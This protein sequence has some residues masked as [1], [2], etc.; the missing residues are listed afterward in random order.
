MPAIGNLLAL[1]ACHPKHTV[2]HSILYFFRFRLSF[3][4]SHHASP[5][6]SLSLPLCQANCISA[7]LIQKLLWL[8]RGMALRSGWMM[9]LGQTSSLPRHD[10]VTEFTQRMS[11]MLSLLPWHHD[12]IGMHKDNDLGEKSFPHILRNKE[13]GSYIIVEA[14]E[15]VEK[16]VLSRLFQ[17]GPSMR[18]VTCT[19]T[20]TEFKA[21]VSDKIIKRKRH[22][23]ATIWP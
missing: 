9:H 5:F 20:M 17:R 2:F 15:C 16:N 10:S 6:L 18:H 11:V 8:V 7:G 3:V 14:M 13:S 21:H 1:L 22:D 23:H 19:K 12:L 4:I